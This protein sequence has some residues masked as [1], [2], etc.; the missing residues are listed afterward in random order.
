MSLYLSSL[1][2]TKIPMEHLQKSEASKRSKFKHAAVLLDLWSS[3]DEDE[4]A[5][6]NDGCIL[7]PDTPRFVQLTSRD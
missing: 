5:R 2:K 1:V 3:S 7:V 6:S 4:T